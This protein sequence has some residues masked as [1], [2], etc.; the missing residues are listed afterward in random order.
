MKGNSKPETSAPCELDAHVFAE[1]RLCRK[2]FLQSGDSPNIFA[3]ENICNSEFLVPDRRFHVS[4]GVSLCLSPGTF[5]KPK[6]ANR[7]PF[8]QH[9]EELFFFRAEQEVGQ[10]RRKLLLRSFPARLPLPDLSEEAHN[11]GLQAENV[12]LPASDAR[13]YPCRH[14]WQTPLQGRE[15]FSSACSPVREFRI[16]PVRNIAQDKRFSIYFFSFI[17]FHLWP[18]FPT[19]RK[20]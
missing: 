18:Y 10:S 2:Q 11:P 1:R 15:S 7:E 17:L 6:N 3:S 16:C 20:H 9:R 14:P 12:S 4:T 5:S 19:S 13:S 8:S